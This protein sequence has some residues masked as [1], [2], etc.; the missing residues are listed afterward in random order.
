MKK[1]QNTCKI[2]RLNNSRGFGLFTRKSSI[3]LQALLAVIILTCI[4]TP[5]KISQAQVTTKN[6][7]HT[8]SIKRLAKDLPK[9]SNLSNTVLQKAITAYNKAK[10]LKIINSNLL[11]I[12]DYSLPATTPRMWVIDM[13]SN[14]ILFNLHVAHGAKSGAKYSTKFSNQPNSH[15]SSI[16]VYK[17]GDIYYGKHGQSLNVHGLESGFNSNA[18]KRRIVIHSA[19]YASSNYYQKT[20]KVGR[21]HGCFAVDPK[22]IKPLTNTLK[23]GSLIVAYYPDQNWLKNSKFL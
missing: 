21:S 20:G 19:K 11:T 6:I 16:G 5:V 15:K 13:Q 22:I 8:S 2:Q 18:F 9:A 3:I 23:Q 14:K 10:Q 12:V 7:I 1:K 4:F 17:T